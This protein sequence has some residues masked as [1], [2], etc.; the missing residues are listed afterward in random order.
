[1]RGRYAFFQ[2]LFADNGLI[3]HNGITAFAFSDTC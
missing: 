3:I 1:V 2:F